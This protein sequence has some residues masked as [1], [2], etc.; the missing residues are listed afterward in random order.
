MGLTRSTWTPSKSLVCCSGMLRIMF[1][2]QPWPS[3][4]LR[5]GSYCDAFWYPLINWSNCPWFRLR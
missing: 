4:G 2:W 1:T 5:H 3:C